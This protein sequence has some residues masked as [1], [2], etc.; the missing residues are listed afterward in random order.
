MKL[1]ISMLDALKLC[2][3]RVLPCPHNGDLVR[4]EILRKYGVEAEEIIQG[5]GHEGAC[6]K[7]PF[8]VIEKSPASM[9]EEVMDA[10]LK[11]TLAEV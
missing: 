1:R 10:Y 8:K 2:G 11:P 7:H 9:R 5:Y 6:I 4:Q 3:Q